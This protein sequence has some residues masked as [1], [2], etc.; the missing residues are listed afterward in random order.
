[1]TTDGPHLLRIYFDAALMFQGR[2]YDDVLLAR[3]REMKIASAAVL[4]VKQAYGDTAIVHG[5]QARDLA[6]DKHLIVELLDTQPKLKA[7]VETLELSVEIGLV[8]LEKVQVV[9]YGGHRHHGM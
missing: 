2:A 8:T 1:M 6:P 5:A 3:A 4:R 9:G 7:F